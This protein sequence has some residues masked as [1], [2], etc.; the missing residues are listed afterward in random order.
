M[1]ETKTINVFTAGH[2]RPCQDFKKLIEEGRIEVDA[3]PGAVLDVVD[4]E[5]E[6]GFSRLAKSK[7]DITLIPAAEY[8]GQSCKIE[9]DKERDVV[10][11]RCPTSSAAA[12]VSS[13]PEPTGA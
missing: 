4:I 3:E 13:N 6:E 9:I 1:P 12:P 10:V 11:I 8:Q 2:C 5:T 7:G